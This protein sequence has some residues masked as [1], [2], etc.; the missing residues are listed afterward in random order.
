MTPAK[1]IERMRVE[2]ASSMVED[3]RETIE[4]IARS[5]GLEDPERMRQSFIRVF[6]QP[7]QAMPKRLRIVEGDVKDWRLFR[8]G[9][10]RTPGTSIDRSFR[11][12]CKSTPQN[13]SLRLLA[14]SALRRCRRQIRRLLYRLDRPRCATQRSRRLAEDADEGLTHPLRV[15]EAYCLGDRFERLSTIFHPRTGSLR[16]QAFNRLGGRHPPLP[17]QKPD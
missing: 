14:G 8:A 12:G 17:Q 16:P 1:A 2:A 3:G 15:R 7:P 11:C 5:V 4:T 9:S 10:P 6:G 13:G